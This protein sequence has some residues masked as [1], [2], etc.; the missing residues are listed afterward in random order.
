MSTVFLECR[1]SFA[2]LALD[3]GTGVTVGLLEVIVVLILIAVAIVIN[4]IYVAVMVALLFHISSC[5]IIQFF[6]ESPQCIDILNLKSSKH[7][8][9]TDIVV[10]LTVHALI[11]SIR[12]FVLIR[13]SVQRAVVGTRF[14]YTYS[15]ALVVQ[16]SRA[17]LHALGDLT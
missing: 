3:F 4:V 6:K 11:S 16:A 5:I 14:Q 1:V 8:S 7:W 13:S 12:R 2:F 17:I 9:N 15:P 10:D